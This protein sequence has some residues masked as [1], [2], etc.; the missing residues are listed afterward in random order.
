MAMFRE[1]GRHATQAQPPDHTRPIAIICL[2]EISCNGFQKLES[3]NP[4]ILTGLPDTLAHTG[5]RIPLKGG[6]IFASNLALSVKTKINA[7][8]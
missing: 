5:R 8:G 6:K 2:Y 4:D 1:S 3:G 7:V